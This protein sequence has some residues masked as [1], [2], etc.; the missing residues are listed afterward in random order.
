MLSS[1]CYEIH[2][3]IQHIIKISLTGSMNSDPFMLVHSLHEH[4]F[5]HLLD[6]FG[7]SFIATISSE[8]C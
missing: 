1:R 3:S 7:E 5:D 4:L 8:Q 2:G 6:L